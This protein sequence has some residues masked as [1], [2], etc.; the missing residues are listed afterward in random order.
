M[1]PQAESYGRAHLEVGKLDLA[2]RAD[3]V[4][5]GYLAHKKQSPP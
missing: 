2:E 5:Q 1:G 3:E 4:V